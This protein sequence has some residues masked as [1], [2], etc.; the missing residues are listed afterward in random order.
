MSSPQEL[1]VTTSVAET[2][3]LLRLAPAP[4]AS[5]AGQPLDDIDFDDFVRRHGM[6]LRSLV[7]RRIGD[8][9]DAEEITQET[10]LRAYTHRHS[11]TVEN[12]LIAWSTVVAQRLVIDRLRV[13]G[14]FVAVAEVPEA[15]RLGRDTADIVV[16]RQEARTALDA[17][18]GDPERARPRSS[19]PARS[20]A[21][22]TRRSRSASTS[23]SRPSARCCTAA[24]GRCARS[25]PAAAARS[26]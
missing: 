10:L 20:R 15:A 4:E 2:A 9:S 1:P 25:T 21:C 22:T 7:L 3:P 16:A 6:R 26:R 24:G 19:G 8:P 23:A 17:L 18:R 5:P 14:R 12:E 11:F 13:R